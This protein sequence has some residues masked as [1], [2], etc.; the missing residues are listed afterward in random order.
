MLGMSPVL[1]APQGRAAVDAVKAGNDMVLLPAD[2]EASYRAL[3]EAVRS[4]EIPLAQIDASVL[5]ILRAKASVG[6]D[7]ARLVDIQALARLVARPENLALAQRV[8]EDAITL[9]R[10]NGKVLPLRRQP[11]SVATTKDGN[12][13]RPGAT[14]YGTETGA[15]ESLLVLIMTDDLRSEYGRSL[16]R[17]IRLRVPRAEILHADSRTAEAM[18]ARVLEAA[19][20]ASTVLAAVYV[21]PTSGKKVQVQGAVSN[22]VSLTDASSAL[23]ERLLEQA[24]P[25]TVV[26]ALGNP[27]LAASF[28][29]IENYLCTFSGVPVS[30]LGAV[31]ALFGEIPIRGRLPVTVPNFARRGEGLSLPPTQPAPSAADTSRRQRNHGGIVTHGNTAQFSIPVH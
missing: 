10:H 13:T 27:Y 5:K 17:E 3:L 12:G 29:R 19:A 15:G 23:I 11:A 30:E 1:A 22:S 18:T 20:R 7:R 16:E 8:A 4:G 24:A 25:K 21:T 31:R 28:P 14:A 2:L 26:V 9:V 6:L